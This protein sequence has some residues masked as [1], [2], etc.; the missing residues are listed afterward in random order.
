MNIPVVHVAPVHDAV[1]V[2]VFGAVQVPLF[3]HPDEHT[4]ERRRLP[5]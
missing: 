1:H 4:A 3:E 2:Q 5:C